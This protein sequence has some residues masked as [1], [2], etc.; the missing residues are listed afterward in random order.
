MSVG[1]EHKGIG[2]AVKVLRATTSFLRRLLILKSV[3]KC[4]L[5]SLSYMFLTR[6]FKSSTELWVN[7]CPQIWFWGV[8]IQHSLQISLLK[9]LNQIITWFVFDTLRAFELS[10][11]SSQLLGFLRDLTEVKN[12][13]GIFGPF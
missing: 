7:R 3:K 6:S 9:H 1:V 8:R 4:T 13:N 12:K 10:L 5:F 11:S 2:L